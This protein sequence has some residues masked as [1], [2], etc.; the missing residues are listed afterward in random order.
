MLNNFVNDSRITRV[1]NILR[2][3]RLDEI[4]QLYNVLKGDMSIVGP[5]PEDPKYVSYFEDKYENYF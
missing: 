4:P 1:G 5:R 3:Y 2:K